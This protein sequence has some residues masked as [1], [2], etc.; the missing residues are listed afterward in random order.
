MGKQAQ[1]HLCSFMLEIEGKKTQYLAGLSLPTPRRWDHGRR[2][3]DWCRSQSP[4]HIKHHPWWVIAMWYFTVECQSTTARSQP[5]HCWHL[6]MKNLC[7]EGLSCA[8]CNPK[9]IPGLHLLD[10]NSTPFPQQ[11]WL[12][13]SQMSLATIKY[14]LGGQSPSHP[15]HWEPTFYR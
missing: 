13:I 11:W 7:C 5:Q 6:G 14:T 2:D 15:T 12:K 10:T 3:E 4:G 1:S 8:L 9:I